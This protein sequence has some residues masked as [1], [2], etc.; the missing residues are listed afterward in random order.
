MEIVIETDRSTAPEISDQS[1]DLATRV[2]RA[3]KKEEGLYIFGGIA[4]VPVLPQMVT[5]LAAAVSFILQKSALIIDGDLRSRS[6]RDPHSGELEP[7]LVELLRGEANFS[8]TVKES[9]LPGLWLLPCGAGVDAPVPLLMSRRLEDVL[10]GARKAYELVFVTIPPV[11]DY[12]DGTIIAPHA[13]G[14][15]LCVFAERHTKSQVTDAARVFDG[16]K[17]PVLGTI[18]CAP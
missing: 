2:V 4:G 1:F 15:I 17:V 11:P 3:L 14:V 8:T 5:D 9:H 18:L 10:A 12:V 16:I 13:D 6:M 7:G